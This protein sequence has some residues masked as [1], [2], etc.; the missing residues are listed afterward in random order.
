[1]KTAEIRERFLRFFEKN[2]HNRVLSSPLVPQNDD[3][4]LFANAG[5]NQFKNIFLGLEQT[6][7]KRACSVQKCVRA[8]GKHNDLENVG[9]TARHLTFFEMLG[10]FSFGDYFKEQAIAYAWELLTSESGFAL[11]VEKLWVTVYASDEQAYVLWRD[12]IGLPAQKII[13]IGDKKVGRYVSDNF[14]QMGEVGPCGPCT[15]IFYD[16]GSQIWGGPPGSSQENGDRFVEIWNCVFMQFDRNQ[17][18]K[19]M[20]LKKPC[21]DTGMGLE[22]M[23]A[24]LQGVKSN[25]ETDLFINLIAAT[26]KELQV[27]VALNNPSLKVIADHLRTCSFLAAEGVIP[28]NEGRGYVLRRIIRRAIRHGFMQ[29]SN[30]PFFYRLV[31]YLVDEMGDAYPEL[32][33]EQEK[34]KQILFTEEEKFFQTVSTGIHYLQSV[35]PSAGKMLSGEVAFKLYDTYGFPLDLTIDMAKE[36]GVGVDEEGFTHLMDAQRQRARQASH[37]QMKQRLDYKG[38]ETEFVG[39]ETSVTDA[40]IEALY[41]LDGDQIKH[42]SSL[43]SEMLGAVVLNKTPFYAEGGG[44]VGD[45]GSLYRDGKVVFEV[46]RTE[47]IQARVFCHW[48]QVKN[49]EALKVGDTVVAEINNAS[50]LNSARN[51]SATHLLHAA[52][53]VILGE[54]VQQRGSLVSQERLRFDFVHPY[55]VQPEQLQAI[56]NLVNQKIR[57]DLPINIDLVSYEEA[58]KRG[59]IALFTEKYQSEVRVV[60]MGS[61]SMELCGGTHVKRTGQIGFFKILNEAGIAAGVRRIDAIT[62]EAFVSW[63]HMQTSLKEALCLKLKATSEE[64]ALAKVHSLMCEKKELEKSIREMQQSRLQMLVDVWLKNSSWY[65]DIQLVVEKSPLS[66]ALLRETLM[67]LIGKANQVVAILYQENK[68]K[69]TVGVGVSKAL[70]TR[71]SAAALL[72]T[73]IQKSGGGKGGGKADLAQGMVSDKTALLEVLGTLDSLLPSIALQDTKENHDLQ[74]SKF[75]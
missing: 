37:F 74:S 9:Y 67:T 70:Q 7:L 16:H 42:T 8:G 55:A 44:Q 46:E 25:F 20:P 39:Y 50:R 62:G 57:E 2:G 31:P 73:I 5:M 53:R 15:E 60:T 27:P 66:E 65:S 38:E 54:Q 40:R 56:E 28:N 61:F 48:G 29:G 32:I 63:L 4:L 43:L 59:A 10:N 3:T 1:M 11:P 34:I 72:K 75:G 26:A 6:D 33:K 22:R 47:K 21:V 19:M 23:A 58:V 52:L 18:G 36:K 41:V 45:K 51:H 30:T 13:R 71:F 14:W 68:D 64:D 12:K 17:T 35:L 49:S 24:V 69:V